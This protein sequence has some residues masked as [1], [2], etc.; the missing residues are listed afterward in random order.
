M[1]RPQVSW[2]LGRNNVL[3][4]TESTLQ[5]CTVPQPWWRKALE[6]LAAGVVVQLPA[7]VL[8]GGR[9]AKPWDMGIPQAL[10]LAAAFSYHRNWW[11]AQ[12]RRRTALH[13]LALL[14]LSL[15]VVGGMDSVG[16]WQ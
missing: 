9:V 11:T 2:A 1:V 14:V 10:F 8:L 15:V 4:T 6:T 13:F 16:W 7:V 3:D 5:T 12:W